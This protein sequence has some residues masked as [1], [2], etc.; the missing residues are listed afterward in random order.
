MLALPLVMLAE[1]DLGSVEDMHKRIARLEA[2]LVVR[3]T[4]VIPFKTLS[5]I[6][7]GPSSDMIENWG[8]RDSS[9]RFPIQFPNNLVQ[10]F[11]LSEVERDAMNE[12]IRI[13][14]EK[15][16][17]EINKQKPSWEK[18][19]HGYRLV[20]NPFPAAGIVIEKDMMKQAEEVLGASRLTMWRY[21]KHWFF[22]FG[23]GPFEYKSTKKIPSETWILDME[24]QGM[25]CRI[26]AS[27]WDLS[28]DR[29]YPSLRFDCWTM[30]SFIRD[31]IPEENMRQFK[32][33]SE[34]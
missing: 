5:E 11:N 28:Q 34:R 16:K 27:P 15:L 6:G 9:G 8:L 3:R 33:D 4:Q 17:A 31:L 13:T 18:I 20:I 24:S 19:E 10:F 14:K 2:E 23:Q 29:S 26:E 30:F 1:D 12:I 7:I 22:G 32:E 25:T 21:N